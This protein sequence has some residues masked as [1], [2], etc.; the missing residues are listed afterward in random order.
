MARETT[1]TT[2]KHKADC[3][4][5]FGRYDLTCDRCLELRMGFGARRGWGDRKR[6]YEARRIAAIRAHDFAACARKNVVCT[7]FD[8]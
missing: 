8:W 3:A 5:V 1:P 7:C 2:T 4:R 6:E